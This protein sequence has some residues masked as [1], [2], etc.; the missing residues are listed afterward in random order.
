MSDTTNIPVSAYDI[1]LLSRTGQKPDR[2]LRNTLFSMAQYM[3]EEELESLSFDVESRHLFAMITTKLETGQHGETC[4]IIFRAHL[5][6]G[7]GK[8]HND[9]KDGDS[10]NEESPAEILFLAPY[11]PDW[12]DKCIAAWEV[13]PAPQ[14]FAFQAIDLSPIF[15]SNPR[16]FWKN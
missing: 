12:R 10:K 5:E 1:H 2:L 7:D 14:L 13:T 4:G 3:M 8:G 15:G 6:Y 16:D 9:R 11:I